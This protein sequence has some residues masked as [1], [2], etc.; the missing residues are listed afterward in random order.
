[1][2][3]YMMYTGKQRWK[4]TTTKTLCSNKPLKHGLAQ[5][6]SKTPT[7]SSANIICECV[8]VGAAMSSL[9]QVA[10]HKPPN[11]GAWRVAFFMIAAAS[12]IGASKYAGYTAVAPL[13][14]TLS[15]IANFL[16]GCCIALA[17]NQ[18]IN[19]FPIRELN[20]TIMFG[21]FCGL[22]VNIFVILTS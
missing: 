19:L 17:S 4:E 22:Q 8:L 6:R 9:K 13:H 21:V 12:A 1:M 18:S 10:T 11:A 16:G 7:M 3:M 14:E 15:G 5:P 20:A 2:I